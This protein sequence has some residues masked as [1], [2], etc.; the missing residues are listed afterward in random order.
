[1][2]RDNHSNR[3]G[4]F[5]SQH[6]ELDGISRGFSKYIRQPLILWGVRWIIGF[7]I[8]GVIV[9]FQTQWSWL[10]SVGGSVVVASLALLLSTQFIMNSKIKETDATIRR[11]KAELEKVSQE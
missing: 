10:W 5:A 9:F 7:A 4:K 11:L 8:I 3:D 2:G 6:N 1:M